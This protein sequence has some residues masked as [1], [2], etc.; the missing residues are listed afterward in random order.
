MKGENACDP[1]DGAA[2]AR[3]V[4]ASAALPFAE[5]NQ[6]CRKPFVPRGAFNRADYNETRMGAP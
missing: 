4:A 6:K 3:N 1:G 2:D 5:W